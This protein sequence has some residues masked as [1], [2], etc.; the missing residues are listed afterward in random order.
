MTGVLVTGTDTGVGKTWVTCRIA[1]ALRERGLRVGVM[2]PCETGMAGGPTPKEAPPGSDA[3]K[4]VRASGCEAPLADVLPYVF[5]L[6]AAPQVA[7]L[8]E[9]MTVE[10]DVLEAAYA[11]LREAHDVVLVEGAGGLLVPLA[12]GLDYVALADK[13]ELEVLVVARTG[14]GTLN[15]TALTDRV[16]RNAGIAPKGIVLNSPRKPLGGNDRA[17][18]SALSSLVETPVLAEFPHGEPASGSV[19]RPVVEAVVGG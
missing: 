9:G 18:L 13:L 1:E 10:F 4:L 6:P 5:K 12:P 7:A 19:V 15:H 11:R 17:N 8:E 3:E 14:L 16:L 2:K